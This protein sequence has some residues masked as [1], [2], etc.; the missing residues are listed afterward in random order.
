MGMES[1]NYK[2]HLSILERGVF[3]VLKSARFIQ[4]TFSLV[5]W[6]AIALPILWA[7]YIIFGDHKHGY[8]RITFR[9][10]NWTQFIVGKIVTGVLK[11]N[12]WLSGLRSPHEF[13]Q[14]LLTWNPVIPLIALK[15]KK[16][17]PKKTFIF[18]WLGKESTEHKGLYD[19]ENEIMLGT[20]EIAGA[21]RILKKASDKE[22]KNI[23]VLC[24][25]VAG[26]NAGDEFTVKQYPFEKGTPDQIY[27]PPKVVIIAFDIILSLSAASIVIWV[28][29][30]LWGDILKPYILKLLGIVAV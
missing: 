24:A 27:F 17:D 9:R 20:T 2:T 15:L 25:W 21:F 12:Q 22:E 6:H 14:M 13:Y 10:E 11:V 5:Y 8:R 7:V 3:F 19:L 26:E 4:N 29:S 23:Q 18:Y 16:P 30:E 1:E 28:V